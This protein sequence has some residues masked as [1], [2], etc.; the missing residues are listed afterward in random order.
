[1]M[2]IHWEH[3]SSKHESILLCCM[4][5]KTWYS[6]WFTSVFA[7]VFHSLSSGIEGGVKCWF[8]VYLGQLYERDKT[9]GSVGCFY[10]LKPVILSSYM[11]FIPIQVPK[12]QL[13]KKS[14]PS[15]HFYF[16]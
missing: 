3:V 2:P 9:K 10:H 16:F 1:M 11:P 8:G 6:R 7:F 12:D 5:I 13:K 4:S 15:G 14:I